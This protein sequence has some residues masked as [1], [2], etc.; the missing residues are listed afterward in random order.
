MDQ[1]QWV[2]NAAARLISNTGK[3]EHGLSQLLHDDLHWLDVLQQVQYKL[4]VTVH[5][6]LRH[7]APAQHS[8]LITMFP[9]L[10]LPVAVS[11]SLSTTYHASVTALWHSCIGI[12]CDYLHHP[13]AGPEQFWRDLKMHLF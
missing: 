5:H 13:T 11:H 2:L 1:L 6:C 4:V 9:S 10:T 8:S 12:H 7:Q 3:Y